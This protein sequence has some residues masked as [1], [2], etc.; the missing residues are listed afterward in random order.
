MIDVRRLRWDP[1][2]LAHIARHQV[3]REEVEEACHGKHV[4]RQ[5]H[6]GRLLLIGATRAGRMIA[7]VLDPEGEDVHYPV[8]AR[9]ASR[10]ERRRYEQ[11]EG[12]A[13]G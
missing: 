7:V 8:T 12:G 11:A 5:T 1:G 6:H 2:N 4:A 9:S 3:T 13:Q 10:K